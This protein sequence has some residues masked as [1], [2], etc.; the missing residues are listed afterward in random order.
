MT[1]EAARLERSLDAALGVIGD[2]FELH[3]EAGTGAMGTVYRARDRS[4]GELV[5]VK[6]LKP[7]GDEARFDREA[8]VL[9]D[10]DHP[11]IV[12]YVAHG[13]TEEDEPYLVMQWLEGE[14][15]RERLGRGP[16]E[17][18]ETIALGIRVASALAAAHGRGIIHRDLKPSNLFLCSGLPSDVKVLDFGV[19]RLGDLDSELT[20]TGQVIGTPGYMAPEQARGAKRLDGR[21]DLFSLGCVLFRAITG[22]PAFEGEDVLTV[23]AELVMHHPPPV[24]TLVP[25]CP[26]GLERLVEQ[27]L[28]KVAAHRPDD[29]AAVEAAL[30]AIERKLATGE[31]A[32]GDET[33]AHERDRRAT[34]V[35]VARR[36]PAK[37]APTLSTLREQV[38]RAGGTL[39]E[40]AG[41]VLVA[42][43]RDRG[44]VSKAGVHELESILRDATDGPVAVSH[45]LERFGT[46]PTLVARPA[47]RGA[48]DEAANR[49]VSLVTYGVLGALALALAVF[50]LARRSPSRPDTNGSAAP[51]A[52]VPA[53][54]SITEVSSSACAAWVRALAAAQRPD[55]SFGVE[56]QRRPQAWAT[57][58][59]VAALSIASRSCQVDTRAPVERGVEALRVMYVNREWG[60]HPDNHSD[61]A[62]TAW[63]TLAL[64]SAAE[65]MPTARPDALAARAVLVTLQR[66]D[67]SF[68]FDAK[69]DR[70]E[71]DA[72]STTIALWALSSLEAREPSPT[73]TQ[74]RSRSAAWLRRALVL[75][76]AEPPLRA[77]PGLVEQALWVLLYTREKTGDAEPGDAVLFADLA[78]GIADRCGLQGEGASR[79][80]SRPVHTVGDV[81]LADD[82][83][84]FSTLWFPWVFA[85]TFAASTDTFIALD[86][87]LQGDLGVIAS[88]ASQEIDRGAAS[89]AGGANYKLAEQI[90]AVSFVLDAANARRP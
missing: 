78:K 9:A 21:A 76:R 19:A 84:N 18:N 55:G 68:V 90:L 46:E 10:L 30:V 49:R 62:M 79:S 34:L 48:I 70:I 83:P 87:A 24:R 73:A 16:L 59:A 74:A 35:L 31:P 85:S 37:S 29:A 22:R 81:R 5:A 58:Q 88:W 14:T 72:Y 89:L 63:A 56:S 7:G 20:R 86:P 41:G 4:T 26:R 71:A 75:D 38:S 52:V 47:P 28:E 77:V 57:A 27:L 1:D 60:D 3:E 66:E 15:L 39:E 43:L 12:R 33:D 8:S 32:E 50:A 65:S 17:T 54:R 44:D 82:E 64:G 36:N 69:K 23:L 45:A 51:S 6:V 80:C 2:R 13:K 11:A 25:D 61:S 42:S 67:G 40:I 53:P